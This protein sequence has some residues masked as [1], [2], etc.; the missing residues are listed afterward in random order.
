MLIYSPFVVY[1][2]AGTFEQFSY[3]DDGRSSRT[4]EKYKKLYFDF[5]YDDGA[6]FWLSCFVQTVGLRTAKDLLEGVGELEPWNTSN[7]SLFV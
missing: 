4:M 1:H 6:K 2:Y 7:S 5:W 3:R